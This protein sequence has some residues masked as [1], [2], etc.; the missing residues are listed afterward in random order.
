MS[1]CLDCGMELPDASYFC[2]RCG[3]RQSPTATHTTRI[4]T[5]L[6]PA[7]HPC[8]ATLLLSA[9]PLRVSRR[10]EEEDEQHR[11]MAPPV[12]LFAG[13]ASSGSVPMIAGQPTMGNVPWLQNPLRAALSGLAAAKLALAPWIFITLSSVAMLLGAGIVLPHL[14][15]PEGSSQ[16]SASDHP[17]QQTIPKSTLPGQTDCV[18]VGHAHVHDAQIPFCTLQPSTASGDSQSLRQQGVALSKR[19]SSPASPVLLP[20]VAPGSKSTIVSSQ[21]TRVLD[22]NT[23]VLSG[24]QQPLQTRGVPDKSVSTAQQVVRSGVNM[25][26]HLPRTE[27][28]ISKSVSTVN[29]VV[30]NTVSLAS[31]Q[32]A[33]QQP[34]VVQNTVSIA[35]TQQQPKVVQNTVST[36]SQQQPKVVQ[37]TVSTTK[38][39]MKAVQS[40]V[41]SPTAS[42]QLKVQH[43]KVVQSTV[44]SSTA[45]Q[46]PKVQHPKVGNA[47][48]KNTSTVHP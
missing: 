32:P 4:S 31:Q 39:Q 28:A 30:Q 8:D 48:S 5:S 33:V 19:P 18:Q 15:K 6:A 12:L 21:V 23:D 43:P 14:L 11:P 16:M 29:H 36:A 10:K 34:K 3:H 13:Q 17:W 24:T 27:K 1:S 44:S 38:Q 25:T 47:L 45:S 2:G 26:P 40:T 41:S 46:Q 42:Q 9:S 20:N 7:L 35:T 22:L 37:N